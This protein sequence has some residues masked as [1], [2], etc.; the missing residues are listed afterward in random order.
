MNITSELAWSGF[1]RQLPHLFQS[2]DPDIANKWRLTVCEELR[3]NLSHH[4]TSRH[5]KVAASIA[6]D[7]SD[8]NIVCLYIEPTA[9]YSRPP[10]FSQAPH[11]VNTTS[12]AALASTTFQWGKHA[13]DTLK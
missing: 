6:A 2:N 5:P 3:S 1:G 12:F 10:V 11:T 9:H 7:F 8:L 13:T 4:L